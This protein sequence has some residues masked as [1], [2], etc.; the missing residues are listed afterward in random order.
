M[1]LAYIN[2]A[3]VVGMRKTDAAFHIHR[4]FYERMSSDFNSAVARYQAVVKCAPESNFAHMA[5][6]M[7][8]GETIS[9]SPVYS[10]PAELTT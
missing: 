1:A 7:L 10:M 5:Q 8:G 4:A 9:G 3:K 2:R 6:E